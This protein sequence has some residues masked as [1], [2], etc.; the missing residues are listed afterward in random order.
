VAGKRVVEVGSGT[1]VVGLGAARL[2]AASVL[3]TD[4]EAV[5][6]LLSQNIALCGLGPG[7]GV[8]AAAL[9]WGQ[10]LLPSLTAA[11]GAATPPAGTV[12]LAADVVYE[13]EAF[14]LLADTLRDLCSGQEHGAEVWLAYRPRHPGVWGACVW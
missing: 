9:P 14:G 10:P 8:T 6:P 11:R 2:G 5:V 13:P 1:G 3:L 4:M 12:V 7:S